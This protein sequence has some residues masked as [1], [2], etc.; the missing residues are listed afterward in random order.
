MSNLNLSQT[1]KLEGEKHRMVSL[2]LSLVELYY[3]SD[4]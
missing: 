1:R 3:R 4:L 2:S